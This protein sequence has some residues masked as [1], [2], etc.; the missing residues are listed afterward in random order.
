[1][2]KLQSTLPNMLL[3][4][5]TITAVAA[6]LLAFVYQTTKPTIEASNLATLQTGITAVVPTHDNNPYEEKVELDGYLLYPARQAGELTGVA[7]ESFTNNGFSGLIRVLVGID[8]EGNIVDYTVLQH[9]ETPGLGSKMEEWFRADGTNQSVL[10]KSLTSPLL[11]SK[12]GGSIDAISAATIS[13]RA[14]LETLNSAYSVM[15]KAISEG[16]IK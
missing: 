12:D 15:Q 2:K 6:A 14:F 13:S 8:T 1:M 3:S 7:V 10:G 16:L 11:V 5:T 4:L 9:A